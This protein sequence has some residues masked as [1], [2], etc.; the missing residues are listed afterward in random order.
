MTETTLT[1]SLGQFLTDYREAYKSASIE[2]MYKDF[3]SRVFKAFEEMENQP[4]Q[5]KIGRMI[6]KRVK[7]IKNSEE[8]V[9]Y[10][11]EKMLALEA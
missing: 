4:A 6:L 3:E 1:K 7:N 2:E 5:K 11:S 9:I 8:F 10:V